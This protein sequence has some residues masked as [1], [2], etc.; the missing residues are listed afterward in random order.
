MEN[1]HRKGE[2]MGIKFFSQQLFRGKIRAM[3]YLIVL[4]SVTAFFVMSV[5]LYKNSITNLRVVEDTYST[6]AVMEL[7][8]NINKFGELTERTA[9][10]SVGYH[11][12]SVDGYDFSDIVAA[13]CVE[14]YDLRSRYGAYIPGEYAMQAM[15]QTMEPLDLVRFRIVGEEPQVLPVRQ[16]KAGKSY[17]LEEI[18]LEILD[19]AA[20]IYKYDEQFWGDVDFSEEILA[21][22][23]Q[24][25]RYLNGTDVTTE[26]TLYPG[27]E[28]VAVLYH[29][30]DLEKD[31]STV[32]LRP[33]HNHFSLAFESFSVKPQVC[34]NRWGDEYTQTFSKSLIDGQ[35]FPL[36]RRDDINNDPELRLWYEQTWESV[37]CSAYSHGVTLTNDLL[38]V[39]VFHLGGAQLQDGR[40]ISEEEYASG[41]KVCMVSARV[42]KLQGWQVGD[43][44]E[45]HFYRYE[46]FPN[47][48]TEWNDNRPVYSHDTVGFFDTGSYEIVG[49]YGQR[50]VTGNSTISENALALTWNTIFLPEQSVSNLTPKEELP[51]HSAL[52]TIWLKNGT[53]D[54]F[55]D[56]VDALGITKEQS[57]TYKAS[58]TFYDQGY[59][60]IQPSLQTMHGTAKLLLIL[61]SVL[62]VV[63]VILMAWFFA[64][65]QKH[66]VGI[67]RMLGGSKR[68][69]VAGLLLCATMIALIGATAGI[70]C[71][72]GLTQAVGNHLMLSGVQRSTE[73]AEFRAFIL[74]EQTTIEQITTGIDALLSVST[75][76]I[77][78]LL[79]V[80]C[81]CTFVGLYIN[82]EPRELLP[83]SKA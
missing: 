61:S 46:G 43:K 3:L 26:L 47:R 31:K 27:V 74:A 57:N 1:L 38:G 69:A 10:D 40:M 37:Y 60:L 13:E 83:K 55:L 11:A 41:A 6:I 21:E 39:P 50:P 23:A 65:S 18:H 62:L 42:A 8:G 45:M 70:I 51:V 52:L 28:Y 16:K 24:H 9:E 32:L 7:Y 15:N 78:A 66:S 56:H 35:V 72:S 79:F 75:G 49:I 4:S 58:F 34:Y 73:D 36:Q 80:V 54:A 2:K 44:L 82:R 12:C 48:N 71:G 77:G 76:F 64:Q 19:S 59:S 29:S 25:I 67:L 53:I 33:K 68:Q 81:I 14:K 17:S 22:Y 30:N 20:G 5:N 63:T